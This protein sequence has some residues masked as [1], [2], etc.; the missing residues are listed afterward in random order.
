MRTFVLVAIGALSFLPAQSKSPASTPSS[1]AESRV[2]VLAA[3]TNDLVSMAIS[4]DGRMLAFVGVSEGRN[5][6]WVQSMESQVARPLPGTEDA[7][8]PFWSPDGKNLGLFVNSN[9]VRMDVETGAMQ[10]LVTNVNWGAGGTWNRDGTILFTTHGRNVIYKIPDT[11]GMPEPVT[12]RRGPQQVTNVHPQF[13]PDGRHFLYYVMG[14]ADA[15]GIY[16][17]QIGNP[18]TRRLVD[19]EAA[20]VYASGRLLFLRNGTLFAQEFD[21][22]QLTLS[23]SPVPLAKEVPIGGRSVAAF[24]SAGGHIIYRTGSAGSVRKLTWFDRSGTELGTVGASFLAGAGAPSLSPDGK[25]V[26][27]NALVEGMGDILTIDVRSGEVSQ[28]T[29]DPANDSYPVWYPDGR[30]IMFSSNRTGIFEIY[31]KPFG[32]S[33]SETLALPTTAY[34]HPMDWSQDGRY[35]LYRTSLEDLWA[36]RVN[37]ME[38]IQILPP[39]SVPRWQQFSPDG[40]W[41]AFQSYATGRNEVHILGPFAPPSLG[42]TSKALSINGGAWVR[43]SGD[44]KELFY[45]ALDGTL[46]SIPLEFDPNGRDFKAGTPVALF[47]APMAGGPNNNSLAQQYMVSR[48]GQ[49]FLVIAAPPVQS[50]ITVIRNWKPQ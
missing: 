43:W 7:S 47:K 40:K 11:G 27:V 25:T 33:A 21:P 4:N 35:L 41:I 8:L 39:A 38:D 28:F 17:G 23:G 24:S 14:T 44:G 20:G 12:F 31:E 34:R 32:F 48:D 3:P 19:S 2:E 15:R 18:E 50:P 45:A 37:G 22:I 16:V 42:Q 10:T 26:V 36:F 30:R 49:R 46:M 5:R 9:L 1:G 13:L 6:I 29:R